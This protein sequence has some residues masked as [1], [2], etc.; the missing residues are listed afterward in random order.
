MAVV[1]IL[2]LSGIALLPGKLVEKFFYKSAYKVIT[3]LVLFAKKGLA[4]IA[5]KPLIAL[6]AGL[7]WT[8]HAFDSFYNS[9][10]DNFAWHIAK[11][12]LRN[13]NSQ[14]AFMRMYFLLRTEIA[15]NFR[16]YR[17][18]MLLSLLSVLAGVS[19]PLVYRAIFRRKARAFISFAHQQE[20]VAEDIETRIS[21]LNLKPIRIPYVK[22]STHQDIIGHVLEGIA[23]CNLLICVPSLAGSFVDSEV[24]A[25][26]AS[27]KPIIFVISDC[28]GTLPNTAD[29]RYP[30]FS[31]EKLMGARY[32]PLAV[33]AGYLAGDFA[34]LSRICTRSAFDPVLQIGSSWSV[35]VIFYVLGFAFFQSYLATSRGVRNIVS[36]S[37]QYNSYISDVALIHLL[38][39][40]VMASFGIICLLY[41]L[42]F[43]RKLVTQIVSSRHARLMAKSGIFRRS[44]WMPV[45]PDLG[46]GKEVYA[47]LVDEA[48]RAHHEL[49]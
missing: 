47:C 1:L 23:S 43:Y 12:L 26:S 7:V 8:L 20:Q 30:V 42:V 18:I 44:D 10:F 17:N 41:A 16:L 24:L 34:S 4:W 45:M 15:E 46:E 22:D 38:F 37:L 11:L 31:L 29:K 19:I 14:L 13:E 49:Q 2:S 6:K 27:R 21:K 3:K 36:Q 25:A 5:L 39:L 40:S 32:R 33:F 35:M 9:W 28:S 48:P